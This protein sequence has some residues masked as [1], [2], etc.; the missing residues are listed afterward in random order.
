MLNPVYFLQTNDC[1]RIHNLVNRFKNILIYTETFTDLVESYYNF[2]T[3]KLCFIWATM[4]YAADFEIVKRLR[5]I[6]Q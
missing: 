2:E 1:G 4:L 5:E 6:L 3:V